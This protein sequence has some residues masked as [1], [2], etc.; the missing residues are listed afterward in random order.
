MQVYISYN[1]TSEVVE[2][3]SRILPTEEDSNCWHYIAASREI[4]HTYFATWTIKISI[5]VN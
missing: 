2:I 3:G 4:Q 5:L 1:L